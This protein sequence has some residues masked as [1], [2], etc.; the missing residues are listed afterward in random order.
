MPTLFSRS[1]P[2]VS[3]H[4]NL[5]LYHYVTP[6]ISSLL[7]KIFPFKIKMFFP[8]VLSPFIRALAVAFVAKS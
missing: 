5:P 1:S 8:P 2:T 6:Q 7:I 3:P 4:Q